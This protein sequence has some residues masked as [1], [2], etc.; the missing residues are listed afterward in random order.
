MARYSLLR[1]HCLS[2]RHL[3]CCLLRTLCLSSLSLFI[4]VSSQSIDWER[5]AFLQCI[6]G[7]L[8]PCLCAHSMDC[9]SSG[10]R[11]LPRTLPPAAVID[12]LFAVTFGILT[13]THTH[14]HTYIHIHRHT[15]TCM[16][17]HIAAGDRRYRQILSVLVVVVVVFL[18]LNLFWEREGGSKMESLEKP[19]FPAISRRMFCLWRV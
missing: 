10:G 9:V 7:T 2:S 19:Y 8:P 4:K 3:L 18:P 1:F 12:T 11:S 6:Q 13:Y 17:Q 16:L 14:T 15:H 5:P